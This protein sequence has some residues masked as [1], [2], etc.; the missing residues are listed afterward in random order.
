MISTIVPVYNI[1]KYL[2]ALIDSLLA[3]TFT[4]YEILIID[5]GN[6]I[7]IE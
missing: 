7:P 6:R 2:P 5:D 3:Q 4:D 1:G